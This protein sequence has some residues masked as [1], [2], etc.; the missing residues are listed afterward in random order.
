MAVCDRCGSEN[1]VIVQTANIPEMCYD[2]YIKCKNC[3]NQVKFKG[4][5]WI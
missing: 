4:E 5:R 3:G 2:Y 1:V